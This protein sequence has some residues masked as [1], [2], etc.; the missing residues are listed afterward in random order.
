MAPRT[1]GTEPEKENGTTPLTAPDPE[2]APAAERSGTEPGTPASGPEPS[3]TTADTPEDTP[4]AQAATTG[5]HRRPHIPPR[6]TP[7]PTGAPRPMSGKAALWRGR[8]RTVPR[9][10]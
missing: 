4:S 6:T 3:T 2:V 5:R 8:A 1:N 10:P 7:L 9:G